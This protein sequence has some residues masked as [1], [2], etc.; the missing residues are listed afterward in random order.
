EQEE[1]ENTD[2]DEGPTVEKLP[3]VVSSIIL[4]GTAEERQQ[5]A[6]WLIE[7]QRELPPEGAALGRFFGCLAAALRGD[8]PEVAA[9]EAPFTDLW[10]VFQ[11]ALKAAPGEES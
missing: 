9:L 5:F 4:Q 2:E 3:G 10:Q 6:E 11:D 8:T 1:T 7:N